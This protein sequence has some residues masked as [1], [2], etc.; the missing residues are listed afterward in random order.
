MKI[1]QTTVPRFIALLIFALFFIY[2]GIGHF[3]QAAGFAEMLPDFV[4]LKVTI[5]YI[6]GILEILLALF[7][8]IPGTRRRAGL[9]TAIYLVLI[10]PANI[11][12]AI[13]HIPAPGQTE[14]DPTLLWIRLL[15]QPLLIWWVIWCSRL[16]ANN[17]W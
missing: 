3:R 11:Y 6:T 14:T 4:P 7:L 1:L 9:W 12:A 17:K 13:E 10:F 16:P 8:V 15:F 2:A 5:I